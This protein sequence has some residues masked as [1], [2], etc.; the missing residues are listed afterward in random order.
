[1]LV[2]PS[3]EAVEFTKAFD[4]ALRTSVNRARTGWLWMLLPDKR[5]DESVD[6]CRAFVD[7]YVAAALARDRVKERP[8]VFMNELVDSGASREQVTGQLLAMVLGGRDTS[9]STLSSLFWTLSRRPEVVRCLRRE[10]AGLEGRRPSW[11]EL[12]ALKYLNNVLKEGS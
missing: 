10:L 1:M 4:Y 2:Q 12:K 6:R 9:A 5:F 3:E 7:S 8:Y 11:E